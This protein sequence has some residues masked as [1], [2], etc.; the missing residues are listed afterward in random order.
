M[1][2]TKTNTL[3]IKGIA[4]VLM[5][6]HHCFLNAERWA[7]VPYEM[8]E[9]VKELEYYPISFVPFSSH[10]VSCKLFKNLCSDVCIYDRLWYVYRL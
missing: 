10:T 8:L 2:F 6:F 4:I 9:K 1:K 5:L 3:Q 7:T